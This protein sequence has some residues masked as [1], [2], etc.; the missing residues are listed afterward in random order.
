MNTCERACP[1]CEG[2]VVVPKD[3]M[4]GEI[5]ACDDC[6][7]ELEV[8]VLEPVRLSIAPAVEEDWGE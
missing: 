3:A 2:S 1:V 6:A 4:L 5:V 7:T 8:E